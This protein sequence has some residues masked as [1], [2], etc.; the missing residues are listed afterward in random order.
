MDAGYRV[1]PLDQGSTLTVS[2]NLSHLQNVPA[3]NTAARK[4][5]PRGPQFHSEFCRDMR[6][7][8]GRRG[9]CGGLV[10]VLPEALAIT[11]R[12]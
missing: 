6:P 7:W 11:L 1:V 3:P 4:N 8:Y 12:A 5:A 2:F 9:S 10:Q